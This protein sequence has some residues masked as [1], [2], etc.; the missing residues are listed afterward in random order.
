MQDGKRLTVRE[1]VEQLK[2]EDMDALVAFEISGHKGKT[3]LANE[4]WQAGTY[5]MKKSPRIQDEYLMED[6]IPNDK[7]DDYVK[8][9]VLGTAAKVGE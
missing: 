7:R 6:E 5:F 4:S 3:I 9:L 2:G 8:V 1:L